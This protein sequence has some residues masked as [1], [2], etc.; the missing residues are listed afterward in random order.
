MT[1]G[2]FEHARCGIPITV[3]SLA[4]GA[5]LARLRA[6]SRWLKSCPS[7]LRGRGQR[8]FAHSHWSGAA[9]IQRANSSLTR[10]VIVEAARPPARV[11][12]RARPGA[13]P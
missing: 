3:L 9:V 6:S 13:A 5:G 2:F 7:A 12:A 8:R 1:L 11:R 10:A 4:V